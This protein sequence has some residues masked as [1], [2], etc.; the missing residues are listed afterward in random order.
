[1]GVRKYSCP[2]CQSTETVKK[3]KRRGKE[4]RICKGCGKWFSINRSKVDS[5]SPKDLTNL[6]LSGYSFRRITQDFGVATTTAYRKVVDYL[7][8]LPQVVDV[9]RDYSTRWSGILVMDGKYVAIRGY[10]NKIPF[11]WAVDYLTHDVPHFKLAP[12]ENYQA[13]LSFFQSLRLVNYSLQSLVTDDNINFRLAAQN[14]YPK[15]VAQICTNHFKET[16][17]SVLRVRSND[18]YKP[19]MK[20]I[21]FIF[22]KKRGVLEFES[23][24]KRLYSKYQND[25]AARQVI[26]EIAKRQPHLLAYT[27]VSQTPYTTNIIESYNSHLQGRLKTIKSFEDFSHAKLW[28]NAYV[29]KRRL[30]KLRSCEGRFKKLNGFAPLEFTLQDQKSLPNFF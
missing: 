26:L 29:L 13:S 17:R 25:D 16:L 2:N 15:V 11:L 1:M 30:T 19:L 24:S 9:S 8:C 27:K 20:E 23:L 12:S 10:K 14:V 3:G 4:R 7:S 18:T 5:L 28:L 21:E 22:S 6:H